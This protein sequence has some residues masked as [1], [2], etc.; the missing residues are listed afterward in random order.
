[1][2]RSRRSWSAPQDGR[3]ARGGL[4]AAAAF[5]ER[6]AL[7]TPGPD[8]RRNGCLTAARAK[9]DAGELDTALGLLVAA[10]AGPLGPLQTA[11]VESLRG[12]IAV[13]PGS[14]QRRGRGF[15]CARPGFLSRLTS[16]WPARRTSEAIW[17]AMFAGEHF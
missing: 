16:P 5:L 3:K 4:A 17:A 1:M 13:L 7:L 15:C 14:G 8:A 12:Q 9:R 2:R 6:A 10:E 11:E